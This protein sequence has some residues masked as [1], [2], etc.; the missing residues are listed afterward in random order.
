MAEARRGLAAGRKFTF[1]TARWL[2]PGLLLRRANERFIRSAS[3]V[4]W[5]E[6]A[7]PS[8]ILVLCQPGAR[9]R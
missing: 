2:N 9:T 8:L 6:G 1:Y 5:S 3:N 4:L 7:R